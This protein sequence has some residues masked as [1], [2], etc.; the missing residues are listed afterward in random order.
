MSN[1]S[2]NLQE[3][4]QQQA[5]QLTKFFI[6][7]QQ[8]V[9]L[10]GQ[11]GTGKTAIFLQAAAECHLKVNYINLSVIER[12]DL[13]GY[14]NLHSTSD[15]IDFKSPIFLPRLSE[16]NKPDSIILFDEVDKA[17]PEVTAPL[18]EILQF[19]KINGQP[20]NIVSCLL[21]GNLSNERVYSNLISTALLDRGAKYLLSFN[22]DKWLEWAKNN[23]VHDLILGFLCSNPELTC[24][25]IEET[26]YASPSPR[27]WTLASEALL[28]ARQ[29]KIV[30]LESV[31]QIIA[32]YVGNE[33][34]LRFQIWYEYYRKFEP[35]V[36]SLIDLGSTNFDFVNLLPTEKIVFV[37]SACYY[38]KFKFLSEPVKSKTKMVYL[39]NLC[40][41]L[42]DFQVETEMQVIA[43][44]NSF[45]FDDIAKYKMYESQIFYQHFTKLTD[46]VS[47]K[48]RRPAP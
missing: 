19:R 17:S 18:L 47:I 30:D 16:G 14:P 42:Q 40:R 11:K 10:F 44:Y 41:F 31:T 35:I 9:F 3:I 36:H 8:N 28:K 15:V 29:L 37:I 33:A 4:D 39:E 1:N 22:F 32:G 7:A 24:G 13:M 34:A 26:N 46:G 27:T 2:L 43:L 23:Q 6:R 12:A 48:K 38:A 5:L 25:T 20:L 45:S 21:T